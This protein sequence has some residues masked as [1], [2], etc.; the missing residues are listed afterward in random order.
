MFSFPKNL[1][2]IRQPLDASRGHLTKSRLQKFFSS[3]P[4]PI[5]EHLEGTVTVKVQS[6]REQFQVSVS[7]SSEPHVDLASNCSGALLPVPPSYPPRRTVAWTVAGVG[8]ELAEEH[9]P[10]ERRQQHSLRLPERRSEGRRRPAPPTPPGASAW[11]S[12]SLDALQ[13][14]RRG[15]SGA[16]HAHC[17]RRAREAVPSR[18]GVSPK[19]DRD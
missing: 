3:C 2:K 6:F 1:R 13:H 10:R 9:R 7:F 14:R 15:L 19:S 4:K 16:E 18:A 12:S 5:V 8:G 11:P 17:R